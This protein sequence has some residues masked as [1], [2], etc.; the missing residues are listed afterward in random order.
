MNLKQEF[1]IWIEA[2]EPFFGNKCRPWEWLK[3][4]ECL[5]PE[6]RVAFW[7]CY[8]QIDCSVLDPSRHTNPCLTV[9]ESGHSQSVITSKCK[10]LLAS[11]S[12]CRDASNAPRD[13][14]AGVA[15]AAKQEIE[16]G[17]RKWQATWWNFRK[18]NGSRASSGW[19]RREREKR[20]QLIFPS[21]ALAKLQRDKD[22]MSAYTHSHTHTDALS[23]LQLSWG[24]RS[25][26]MATLH[27][28]MIRMFR[29]TLINRNEY[30][31]NSCYI[32]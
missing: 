26:Q 5:Q 12:Y 6:W 2:K 20:I 7:K 8:M 30:I 23:H 10:S 16:S 17:A 28:F 27:W 14:T 15:T 29:Y 4:A 24:L 21:E 1:S 31:V 19:S 22:M 9:S 11:L 3:Q 13:L 32:V 18:Q 25:E